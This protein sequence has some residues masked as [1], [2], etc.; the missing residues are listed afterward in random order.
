MPLEI[1]FFSWKVSCN[2]ASLLVVEFPSTKNEGIEVYFDRCPLAYRSMDE[3]S[4]LSMYWPPDVNKSPL[5]PI[6]LIE[7]GSDFLTWLPGCSEEHLAGC[8]MFHVM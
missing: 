1:D 2:D 3:G 4:W 6:M 7:S 5:G 8:D